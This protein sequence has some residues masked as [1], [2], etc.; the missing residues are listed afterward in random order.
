MFL[1]SRMYR[2]A[3]K[4]NQP[5]TIW[6]LVVLPPVKGPEQEMDHLPPSSADVKNVWSYTSTPTTCHHDTH[7]ANF[8]PADI[9]TGA[10]CPRVMCVTLAS[11]IPGSFMVEYT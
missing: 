4:P 6:L 5:P 1:F 7:R 10:C 8:I 3:M 9:Q 2:P 11:Q